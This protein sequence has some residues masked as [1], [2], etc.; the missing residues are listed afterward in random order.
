[1]GVFE[2]TIT[3][4]REIIGETGRAT[5]DLIEVQKLKFS[6]SSMKSAIRKNYELLGQ[7]TYLSIVN[8][9]DN[10]VAVE[11]LAAEITDQKQKLKE[12]EKKIADTKGKVV[13][14][15]GCVNSDTAKFCSNCGK[16]L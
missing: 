1:M 16:E 15:C 9:E 14:S 6:V 12:L 10:S 13:C 2:D 4:A 11:E 7:Y 5:T 3:K 8:N